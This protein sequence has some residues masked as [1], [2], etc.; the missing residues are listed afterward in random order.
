MGGRG[1]AILLG[2]AAAAVAPPPLFALACPRSP[3]PVHPLLFTCSRSPTLV[4][5]LL[6]TFT[7][8]PSCL[9]SFV[10]PSFS[11]RRHSCL[12]SF[13]PSLLIH[14][15]LAPNLPPLFLPRSYPPTLVCH[16]LPLFVQR[17]RSFALALGCVRLLGILL[18]FPIICIFLISFLIFSYHHF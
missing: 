16:R 10:L 9:P 5:P 4:H 2:I 6:F 3:A 13:V 8:P 1:A 17:T 12:P 11:A 7:H 15:S 18:L 14:T